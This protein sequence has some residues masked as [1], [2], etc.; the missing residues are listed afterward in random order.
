MEKRRY[1]T[2]PDMLIG[3]FL[4]DK[5]RIWRHFSGTAPLCTLIRLHYLEQLDLGPSD[6]VKLAEFYPEIKNV[7][8]NIVTTIKSA[9]VSN[10]D[11][12]AELV[13]HDRQPTCLEFVRAAAYWLKGHTLLYIFKKD[14][15]VLQWT[16]VIREAQTIPQ[17]WAPHT[18][19]VTGPPVQL[20][21]EP[22]AVFQRLERLFLSLIKK[23]G[24]RFWAVDGVSG[25]GLLAAKAALK[26]K[27]KFPKTKLIVV[28]PF[29]TIMANSNEV[30]ELADKVIYTQAGGFTSEC[31]KAKN[32]YLIE[33][34]GLVAAYSYYHSDAAAQIVHDAQA[35]NIEVIHLAEKP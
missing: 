24:I 20:P 22:D 18:A 7:K 28:L 19:V 33:H 16:A 31:I 12:I 14:S 17:E 13:G 1:V 5:C 32:D 23:R 26:L 34:A 10:P 3:E 6:F 15:V 9:Y 29:K 11:F 35:K 2:D 30:L 8:S 25:F 21:E 27:K 4:K